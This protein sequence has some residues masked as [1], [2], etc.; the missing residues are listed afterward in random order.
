M[1]SQAEAFAWIIGIFKKY[2]IP[3]LVSG[4]LAANSYGSTRKIKDFDFDISSAGLE[5]IIDA[6][7]PYVVSGPE[8]HRSRALENTLL[9]LRYK[10]QD[11]DIAGSSN[12]KIYDEE[13]SVWVE[14]SVDFSRLEEKEIFGL[15]VPVTHP[16]DLIAYK[17]RFPRP[18]DI[19]DIEAVKKY[20]E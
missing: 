18:E 8:K 3:F 12:T 6:V 5:K 20:L 10:N 9:K 16:E 1:D 7:R 17:S 11:I 13:K 15:K 19:I 14:D 2:K 4:G